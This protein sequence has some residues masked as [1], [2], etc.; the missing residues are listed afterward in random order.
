MAHPKKAWTKPKV[1]RFET[2][3]DLLELYRSKGS[4]AERIRLEEIVNEVRAAQ[5]REA[6]QAKRRKSGNG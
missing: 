4:E 3:E 1:Q 5:D 6:S 2:P